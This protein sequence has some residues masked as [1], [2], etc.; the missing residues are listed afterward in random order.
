MMIDGITLYVDR[1]PAVAVNPVVTAEMRNISS[2]GTASPAVGPYV[3]T[4]FHQHP[5]PYDRSKQDIYDQHGKMVHKNPTGS[6]LN[7]LI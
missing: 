6:Q 2:I 3:A 1:L 7:Q 5:N 4:S